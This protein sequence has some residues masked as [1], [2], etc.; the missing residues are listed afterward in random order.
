MKDLKLTLIGGPTVLIEVGGLRLLTDP[1]FDPPGGEYVLGPVKLQ[2][3]KGPAISISD[4]GKI[5]AVLLS[6]EQHSDNLDYLGRELLKTVDIVY[7]TPQS[8][9]K[10]GSN[11][12]GLETWQSATLPA[13]NGKKLKI[14]STPARHGPIGIEPKSG[15]VTGFILQWENEDEDVIYFSGDTVWYEGVDEI[16]RKFNIGV[17]I[18]NMGAAQIEAIGAIELTMNA[19]GAVDAA[20]A[21]GK[22]KIIP[23]HYDGWNH[24]KEHREAVDK[25]FEQASLSDRLVWLQPGV[26]TIVVK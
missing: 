9:S 22:S 12:M 20:N 2:K 3:Q 5:H 21:F 13:P 25:I 8:S 24:W 18:L 19:H 11:A 6:H 17:A 14:T 23:A 15:D 16:A 26:A 10:L 4:I 7:T 1:T